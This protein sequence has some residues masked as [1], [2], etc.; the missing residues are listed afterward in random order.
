MDRLSGGKFFYRME[1]AVRLTRDE[2]RAFTRTSQSALIIAA[3]NVFSEF[4]L[5]PMHST[6]KDFFFHATATTEIY[7]LS[8]HDALPICPRSARGGRNRQSS[9]RCR[10]RRIRGSPWKA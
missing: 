3:V 7:T 10:R 5:L 1:R 8:L 9:P 6:I 4:L 2:S